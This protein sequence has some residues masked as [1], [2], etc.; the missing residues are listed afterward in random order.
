MGNTV[1]YFLTRL[2]AGYHTRSHTHDKNKI[3]IKNIIFLQSWWL[4]KTGYC[5]R[6]YTHDKNKIIIK[7]IIFLQ[8]WWLMRT[9]YC[10]RSHTHDK[11]KIIIF[12]QVEVTKFVLM[13]NTVFSKPA[14]LRNQNLNKFLSF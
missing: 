14:I 10:I 4:M 3:I 13:G 5:T 11:N 9:G 1:Y 7:N 2:V 6:S 12:L 8:S